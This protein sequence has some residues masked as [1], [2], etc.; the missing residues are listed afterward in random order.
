MSTALIAIDAVG[1]EIKVRVEAGDKAM[2]KAE[3][4]YI[5][6]GI[7]LLEAH[8]RLR[9]T[10]EMRWSAFLFSH[11]RL[12]EDQA[13]RY[14]MLA[15]G[16]TTL[17]EIR[18]TARNNM[19]ASRAR[20]KAGKEQAQ[21]SANVSGEI[22]QQNQCDAISEERITRIVEALRAASPDIVT[23]IERLLKIEETDIE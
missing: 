14:M 9:E 1:R 10:R 5:A 6:A 11:A 18:E 21:I 17:D 3:Q 7:Q 4:H 19:R 8:K 13:R 22:P 15:N 12:S 2:D 23:E 20:V 16:D